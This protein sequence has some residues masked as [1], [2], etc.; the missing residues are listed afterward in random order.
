MENSSAHRL[1][2]VVLPLRAAADCFGGC[3]RL[4]QSATWKSFQHI[5]GTVALG[6]SGASS[7]NQEQL[8]G[9]SEVVTDLRPSACAVLTAGVCVQLHISWEAFSLPSVA[10]FH[11]VQTPITAHADKE[12]RSVKLISI[13]EIRKRRNV[14]QSPAWKT[15]LLSP[16]TI[17]SHHDQIQ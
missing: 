9:V 12:T 13:H 2:Y 1:A 4:W 5:T 16:N 17:S 6:R 7:Q 3:D 14:S 10:R 8:P 11:T 15:K